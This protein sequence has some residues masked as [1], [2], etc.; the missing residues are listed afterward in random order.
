MKQ[1]TRQF[2]AKYI[3]ARNQIE[4]KGL[5]LITQA[6]RTQYKWFLDLA[7]QS[8]TSYWL[9]YASRISKQ[10]IQQFF[11]QFYPMSA[12]LGIMTYQNMTKKKSIESDVL[13]SAYQMRMRKL[14]EES[15]YG[16]R[17]VTIT[18]TTQERI[19]SVVESVLSEAELNGYGIDKIK[20]TL[21]DAIGA[22]FRG[23]AM[24]R[25]KA[26]AQTEMISS[27][28][29]AS[30]Y[31]ADSTGMEYR[32]YWSTS[33]LQGIR[34]SHIIAE[35]DSIQRGGLRKDELFANG[36]RFPGDPSAPADEVINCRCSVLH[37]II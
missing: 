30:T 7:M 20:T 21:K 22:N 24:A 16:A 6:L 32:K 37:E 36:L 26:I 23:N 33:H 12:H 3:R 2:E 1:Q 27:S 11:E 4:R 28:N 34:P 5:R 14:L 35:Q 8:S 13:M 31:A 25:A 9:E 10:P 29:Q 19:T 18:G 15:E 17:I